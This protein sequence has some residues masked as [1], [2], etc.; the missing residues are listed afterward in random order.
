MAEVALD[1]L[2]PAA[3]EGLRRKG[4]VGSNSQPGRLMPESK[5]PPPTLRDH[6]YLIAARRVLRPCSWEVRWQHQ[7][8]AL[9][10]RDRIRPVPTQGP[11]DLCSLQLCGPHGRTLQAAAPLSGPRRPKSL[12][13]HTARPHITRWRHKAVDGR[14]HANIYVPSPMHASPGSTCQVHRAMSG[15]HK[16]SCGQT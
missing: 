11:E 12:P 6:G 4:L 5:R 15:G 1:R 14:Q 3:V 16:K 13:V 8:D 9:V 10:A 7:R 2:P